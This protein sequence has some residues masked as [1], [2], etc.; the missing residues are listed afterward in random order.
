MSVALNQ[1]I[2]G[3]PQHLARSASRSAAGRT[4]DSRATT[5]PPLKTATV[6]IELMRKRSPSSGTAS[7]STLTTR[8][9]PDLWRATLST[10]GAI[11]WHG[12][13]HG[14]QKSTSTGTGDWAMS[15]SNAA[16]LATSTGLAGEDRLALHFAQRGVRFK[17]L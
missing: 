9:W 4:P 7:V 14:A 1:G 2:S 6:G 10:S 16:V 12:P 13:H 11:M 8:A 5:W 17:F 3:K 15:A